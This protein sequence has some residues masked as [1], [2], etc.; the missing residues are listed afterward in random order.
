MET[1]TA[2]LRQWSERPG[3]QVLNRRR[4]VLVVVATMVLY[5]AAITPL[6]PFQGGDNAE[7]LLLARSLARGQGFTTIYTEPPEPHTKYPFLFPLMLAGVMAVFGENLVVM[8]VLIA[9]CAALTAGATLKLWEDRGDKGIALAAAVLVATVP[10]TLKYSIRVLS[11]I[12]FAAFSTLALLFAERALK[13]DS[14]KSRALPVGILFSL[15]AYFTRSIGITLFPALLGATLLKAPL[16]KRL[17]R[18][19][20]LAAT[21]ALPFLLA[22]GAWSLRGY[23]VTRGQGDNYLKEFIVKDPEDLHSPRIGLLDLVHRIGENSP[24]YLNQ[25]GINLLPIPILFHRDQTK[26]FGLLIVGIAAIGFLRVIRRHR[27]APE[28]FTLAYLSLLLLWGFYEVRFLIPL[29]PVLLYYLFKGMEGLGRWTSFIRGPSLARGLVA[30]LTLIMLSSNLIADGMFL[31]TIAKSRKERAF[32]I[33]PWFQIAATN[34]RMHRM[35][36]LAL[37]LRKVAEPEAVILARKPSLVALATDRKVAGPPFPL[38]PAGFIADMEK[39]HVRYILVDEYYPDV[40]SSFDP[41]L[42]AHP[43]RFQLVYQ[44]PKTR[45][46]IYEFL[47]SGVPEP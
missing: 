36:A 31:R 20:I 40:R 28:L 5:L 29:F 15:A 32:E 2:K 23:L 41:A 37:A 19:L 7:Y 33:N 43:E 45:S 46:L 18:N 22:A 10:Y 35:L 13:Q 1:L 6:F 42:Q 27:G 26:V 38:D 47:P 9:V 11:E 24:Y 21:I 44:L 4:V 14:V 25:I 16:R 34:E 30:A 8:K 17:P 3:L 39:R 12:P